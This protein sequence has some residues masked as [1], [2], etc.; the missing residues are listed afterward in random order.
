MFYQH[1]Q[2]RQT[3]KK[4]ENSCLSLKKKTDIRKQI[5]Y[6]QLALYHRLHTV[7]LKCE[8]RRSGKDFIIIINAIIHE[9]NTKEI[10]AVNE[11]L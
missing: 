11:S 1:V 7:K 8:E 4:E 3:K 6:I 10:I 5:I 2:S 9:Q